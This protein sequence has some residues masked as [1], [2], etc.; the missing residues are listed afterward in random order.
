LGDAVAVGFHVPMAR[1]AGATR[2]EVRDTILLTL[3]TSG[4]GGV[5]SCLHVALEAYDRV[6]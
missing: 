6:E 1:K 2:K 3:A 4:V 5:A